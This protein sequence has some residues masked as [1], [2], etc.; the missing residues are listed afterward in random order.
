MDSKV[1]IFLILFIILIVYI[2]VASRLQKKQLQSRFNDSA[3]RYKGNII[4]NKENILNDIYDFSIF[5][6]GRKT[7]CTHAFV[8]NEGTI[9]FSI[10]LINQIA[11]TE[12]Q[13]RRRDHNINHDNNTKSFLVCTCHVPKLQMQ[14]FVLRRKTPIIEGIISTVIGEK[15]NEI[16][17]NGSHLDPTKW[18]CQCSG[19]LNS[20]FLSQIAS[21]VEKY[22]DNP[23]QIWIE[24][25]GQTILVSFAID[26]R[27]ERTD[28][29]ID[30]TKKTLAI[31]QKGKL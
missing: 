5:L 7:S 8:F 18:S 26:D 22:S 23:F 14:H 6:L 30:I 21:V 28:E 24:A 2:A 10:L 16:D 1:S 15:Y 17:L 29:L 9:K 19:L 20:N 31:F 25:K 27:L 3:L 12:E 11:E 13:Y 4:S